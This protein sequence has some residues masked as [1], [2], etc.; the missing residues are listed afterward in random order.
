METL[1]EIIR[2]LESMARTLDCVKS[3]AEWEDG[4]SD[5]ADIYRS[6]AQ[7]IRSVIVGA[8]AEEQGGAR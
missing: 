6:V 4:P 8:P 2:D 5:I 7:R 1:D 3:I